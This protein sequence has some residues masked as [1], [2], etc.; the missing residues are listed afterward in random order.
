MKLEDYIY[1]FKAPNGVASKCRVRIFEATMRLTPK[2][3]PRKH[4]A[5]IKAVRRQ[6]LAVLGGAAA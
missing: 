3:H 6:V 5:H 4:V 1:E 2:S